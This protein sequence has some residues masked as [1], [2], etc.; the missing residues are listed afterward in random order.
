MIRQRATVRDDA[1]H[2]RQQAH[3][4]ELLAILDHGS[5]PQ[6]IADALVIVT[7]PRAPLQPSIFDHRRE[8]VV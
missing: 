6:Q 7:A 8:A 1:W 4:A 3:T 5:T 2:A